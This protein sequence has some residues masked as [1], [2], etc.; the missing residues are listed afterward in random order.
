[1]EIPS[2]YS[3]FLK[4]PFISTDTRKI[5][6]GSIF[7][8]LK[9]AQFDGNTFALQAIQEGAA[10]AVVSDASLD[11]DQL[12]HVEDTLQTLQTLANYH[13]RQI[14]VPV[15]AIT[16]SNGKTTTKE[17]VTT[18]LSRKFKVHATA[19]NLNNHI[20]VPLT[21][22][23]ITPEVE[24]VVCEMGAN[25]GGEIATLCSIAEPTHGLITNIGKAH[26]EGFGSLEGVKKAKGEL[27]DFLIAHHGVGF[28]NMD[29]PNLREI[30]EGLDQKVTFGFDSAAHPQ[31][32]FL[33]AAHPGETGFTMTDKH[34]GLT[35]HSSMF[36]HY[37]ASNM[38]AALAV[39]RHFNV[40]E[41]LII[42]SLS[43][44]I[45]RANRS[46]IITCNGCLVVKDAYNA[47]PSSM[48]LAV[49]A[50]AAQ[51]PD[52]F[53]VLGDMKEVGPESSSAH[54]QMLEL[55]AGMSFN[56]IYVVGNA[57]SEAYE[58]LEI[59]DSRILRF[60]DIHSLKAIWQWDKC[61]GKAMLL[62]GSRSMKLELLLER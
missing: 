42:D 24:F 59:N 16:G 26:L 33:Y 10:Y 6:P 40:D 60:D 11:G 52:G 19:G 4:F 49:R 44:F 47:N 45:P 54:R 57:F 35:F 8:A 55:V 36:G 20:G 39:G 53:I 18:V 56:H 17:L 2:L 28:V 38:L 61:N 7:F 3:L 58:S 25:H 27:F 29:D 13:R 51:Y 5:K 48:E 23:G 43:G 62:K 22:L 46:E 34:S 31:N 12:I 37:N 1:M 30:G 50:F 32:D 9:G 15:L 21:L 41:K 14:Q